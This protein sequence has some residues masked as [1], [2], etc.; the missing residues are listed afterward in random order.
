MEE[1]KIDTSEETAPA[2]KTG[3]NIKRYVLDVIETLVLA[4]LLFLAINAITSRI[5]VEGSSM[6]PTLKNG[7][8]LLVNKLAY[9]FGQPKLGDVIVFHF[10]G[11]PTQEYIKRVIG[12]PGDDVKIMDGKV[13]V[14]GQQIQETYLAA[15][16]NYSG[17]WNVPEKSLFVLG[18]NRNNSSDSHEWG[19]VPMSK[20]IGKALFVYWP[21]ERWSTIA[22][23]RATQSA[24]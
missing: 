12:L 24:P 13:K 11:D 21:P 23:I 1:F 18:D 5:R 22:H 3:T 6:E 15:P 14:N 7:E 2:E 20:I 19:V 8:L 9:K 17:E 10:P 4:I 16:V